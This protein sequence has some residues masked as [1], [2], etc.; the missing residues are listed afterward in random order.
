MNPETP[1]TARLF[2]PLRL[3]DTPPTDIELHAVNQSHKRLERDAAYAKLFADDSDSL[4]G[5][6]NCLTKSPDIQ[7]HKRGCK[8]RLISERNACRAA[9][10]EIARQLLSGEMDDR[11]SDTADWQGGYEELV[12]IARAATRTPVPE[13]GDADAGIHEGAMLEAFGPHGQ[14]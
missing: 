2:A 6:C 12:K 8:Y 9:L 5:S 4:V 13:P 10:L 3:K 1:E 7:Y 11:T 14:G